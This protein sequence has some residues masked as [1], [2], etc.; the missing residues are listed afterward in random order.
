MTPLSDIY[1]DSSP[2]S[3]IEGIST[4][5]TYFF[6][7]DLNSIE[8]DYILENGI[9]KFGKFFFI[10]SCPN[11]MKCT[12]IRIVVDD[13][14]I[15]KEWRRVIKKNS[16]IKMEIR[17]LSFREEIFEIYR[18]HSTRFEK[19]SENIDVENFKESFFDSSCPSLQMEY[20]LNGELIA[21]DFLDISSRGLSSVYFIF[22]TKYSSRSLGNYSIIREIEYAKS[23]GLKY[24]YL[25]YYIEG[26]QSMEYKNRFKPNEKMDWNSGVWSRL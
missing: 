25:G 11:C 20:Y 23:L 9:R 6:A 1:L 12:P 2:C 22:K 24:Y 19:S 8:L 4:N 16:D 7:E 10:N 21:V 26:N 5:M 17:E 15:T 18:D 3:Y 13:F 14:I